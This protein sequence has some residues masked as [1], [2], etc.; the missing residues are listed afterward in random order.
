[1]ETS[2]V[3]NNL[4]EVNVVN[5]IFFAPAEAK[6]FHHLVAKVLFLRK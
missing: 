1:M 4:F 5:P 6:K 2:T 3:A